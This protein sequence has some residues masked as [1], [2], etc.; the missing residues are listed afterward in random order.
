MEPP[1]SVEGLAAGQMGPEAR[2]GLLVVMRHSVRLD[3]DA[4]AAWPDKRARPYDSPISDFAL[5]VTQAQ[6]LLDAGLGEFD[7]L[8][9]SPFRRALQ[10]A[11]LVAGRLGGPTRVRIDKRLGEK[12]RQ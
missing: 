9:C 6:A 7:V 10:T 8:I 1:T 2:G 4:G 12:V 3:D 5:P 11:A